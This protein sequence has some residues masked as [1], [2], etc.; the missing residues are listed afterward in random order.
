MQHG[1]GSA[2]RPSGAKVRE[3]H[4]YLRSSISWSNNGHYFTSFSLLY[5]RLVVVN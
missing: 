1:I 5:H 3:G 2:R 4:Q